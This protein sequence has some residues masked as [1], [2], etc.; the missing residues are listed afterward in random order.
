MKVA[1]WLGL[2]VPTT[3]LTPQMTHFAGPLQVCHCLDDT[4]SEELRNIFILLLNSQTL[5]HI[6][7]QYDFQ[8]HQMSLYAALCLQ[9]ISPLLT[10]LLLTFTIGC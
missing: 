9:C 4:H 10:G 6:L 3:D 2:S 5:L 8:W 7:S 1:V